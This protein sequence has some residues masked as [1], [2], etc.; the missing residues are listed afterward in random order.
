MKP[1][2]LHGMAQESFM[3]HPKECWRWHPRR[4]DTWYAWDPRPFDPMIYKD[5]PHGEPGDCLWVRE[6]F[7]KGSMPRTFYYQAVWLKKLGV[8]DQSSP[9]GKWRPSIFM[10]RAACRIELEI[11][12]VRVERVYEI[13]D[14]DARAEGVGLSH[15]QAAYCAGQWVWVISFKRIK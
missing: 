4:N 3:P 8:V 1:Q 15:G 10:P 14:A 9:T 13:T 2:P 6:T 12:Q 11:M 7:E 5:C